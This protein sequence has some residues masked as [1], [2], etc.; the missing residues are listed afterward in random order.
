MAGKFGGFLQVVADD[1]RS[2]TSQVPMVENPPQAS[3]LEKPLNKAKILGIVRLG[4]VRL[5]LF[6]LD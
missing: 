4:Y 6:R 5:G 3:T 2:R 1:S